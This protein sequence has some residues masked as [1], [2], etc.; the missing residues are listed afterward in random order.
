MKRLIKY[1]RAFKRQMQENE[2]V[3]DGSSWIQK[4][5]LN[6]RYYGKEQN[7]LYK[8]QPMIDYYK[9]NQRY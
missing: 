7:K 1:L 4:K 5:I 8:S 9:S 3:I 6:N 2:N